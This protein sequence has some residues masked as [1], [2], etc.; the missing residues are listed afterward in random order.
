MTSPRPSIRPKLPDPLVVSH[1]RWHPARMSQRC[2]PSRSARSSNGSS[3][4]PRLTR[5]SAWSAHAGPL[6][7]IAG[8]VLR[9]QVDHLPSGSDPKPVW[10]WWSKT[11]ASGVNVDRCW[12]AFL[13]RFDIE[14]AF[15][16]FKHPGLDRA[17][18][19]EPGLGRPVDLAGDHRIY[20][21]PAGPA[22]GYDLRRPWEKPLPPQRLSLARVRREFRSSAR[23]R[24]LQRVHRNPAAQVRVVRR[25]PATS[26]KLCPVR[27]T[28]GPESNVVR[29]NTKYRS[30]VVKSVQRGERVGDLLVVQW[31]RM[32]V[33]PESRADI[34][35]PK[36]FGRL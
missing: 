30:L 19:T 4:H 3:L 8:T 2:P 25:D 16:L 35:V 34:T 5:R 6:P 11:N 36:S 12:Q 9:P 7:I 23:R 31:Q 27:K 29:A 20:P 28:A 24:V 21:A 26:T 10:F 1:D 17:P 22:A 33:F 14:H 18:A 13:R 15:R 32:S